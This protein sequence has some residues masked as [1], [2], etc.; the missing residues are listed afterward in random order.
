MPDNTLYYGDNLDVLKR[1]VASESVD[2]VY[3]D[4]PFQSGRDYNVLFEERSG[5][6]STAQIKAFEDTWEWGTDSRL[7]WEEVVEAG[8]D[9][10]RV[11]QAFMTFLGGNDMMAYLAMMAPRLIELRRVLKSA[12]SIY[13]HCD[14]TASHYLKIL[15]DSIFGAR[16]FQNEII[17]YYRG[18][19]ISPRR[20]G[21][22]HDVILYYAKGERWTFNVDPVRVPYSAASSERLEYT[23]RAFRGDRVY[24]NYE[25]NPEG[26]HPDDVFIMQP[27]MPSAKERLG[28]PTQ[29]PERLLERVVLASSNEGDVVLDPF[30]GCGTTISVAHRLK[31]RWIGID[32]THLAVGLI[33]NRLHGT[34]GPSVVDTYEVHG[35]PTA[36]ADAA[37]LA[38]EDRFEFENWALGRVDARKVDPKKGADRGIDGRLYFHDEPDGETRQIVLSVK[39]GKVQVQHVR[40][41]RGVLD[42]EKADIGVLI[43][44]QDPTRPM[45]RE[46]ASAGF[47]ESPWG[48]KH[49]RLQILTITD[50]LGG[51][52]IDYPRITGAAR[53]YKQAPRHVGKVAEQLDLPGGTDDP[54]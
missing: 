11:M 22:K 48:G 13:L 42:R 27:V 15:M 2:L 25:A 5:D 54:G 49:P 14:P 50:L 21:R 31:R 4:P 26:K 17:W 37:A 28:Y 53:T 39:S 40:D 32:V 1:H 24:E 51:K 45:L 18:G 29:K 12:G 35:E 20:W 19:G 3:L 7:A 41:L 10:S 34:F 44:L 9:T 30:C 52:R 47:Y 36:V 33:K 38:L 16:Q 8:E 46:V 23:A 6:R 43:T